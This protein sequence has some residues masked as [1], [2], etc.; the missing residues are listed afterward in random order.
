MPLLQANEVGVSF[1]GLRALHEVNM[2]VDAGSITGLIG[3]N[4]AGKTTMFNVISGLIES[5]D[6]RVTFDERTLEGLK[7]HARARLGIARTFQRLE[8]FGSLTAR[9][10]VLVA[11]EIRGRWSHDAVDPH[12]AADEILDTVGLTSHADQRADT[13]PT[14]LLRLVELARALATGPRL[15]LLDEASSGLTEGETDFMAQLLKRL[16]AQG[17]AVLL[18]EHDI[19]FVMG[20]CSSVHVLDFGRLI[21]V[22][23]PAE[24]QANEEVQVAYLG[25]PGDAA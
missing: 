1:G 17:L 25:Q 6:G 18:V 12:A 15:L 23:T 10:N 8:V 2:T 11:A 14:G 22:G 3:P 5:T 13:M 21:A 20:L 19:E 7:P 9:E 4:G 24:I 16:A